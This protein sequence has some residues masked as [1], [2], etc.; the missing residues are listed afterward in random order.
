MKY[1]QIYRKLEASFDQMLHPQKRADMKSALEACMG[2]LLEVRHYLVSLV[3]AWD[4]KKRARE[5]R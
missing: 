1:I 5:G 3:G 2:R 4:D